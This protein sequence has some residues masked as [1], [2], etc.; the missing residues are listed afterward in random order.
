MFMVDLLREYRRWWA[1]YKLKLGDLWTGGSDRLFVQDDGMPLNPD[2][3]NFWLDKFTKKNGLEHLNPHALRHTFATLQIAAGVDIRTLQARTGHS[4][5][6]TLM[7]IYSPM[8]SGARR[9]LRLTP[10]TIC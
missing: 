6:S 3:I 10:W 7:N 1:E 8:Q 2:T 4:Q 5:D 9:R